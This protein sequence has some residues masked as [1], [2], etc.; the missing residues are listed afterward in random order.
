MFKKF[1]SSVLFV[2]FLVSFNLS[3]AQQGASEKVSSQSPPVFSIPPGEGHRMMGE[4]KAKALSLARQAYATK[5]AVGQGD[6]DA[7]YYGLDLK[8]DTTAK[9]V[10]GA[11]TM[12]GK[13]K[14]A[15]L[16]TVILD[17]MY[18][19]VVDS[20]KEGTNGLAFTHPSNLINITLDRAYALDENFLF[21]VYYHGH[22]L[23]GGFLDFA[24]RY[25]GSPQVPIISS[26]SEPYYA[27]TWWPC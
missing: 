21:T 17:L 20:V 2:L 11:V 9:V 26:L 8:I 16:N 4:A 14:V 22:P 23:E 1:F 6:F 7:L 3:F 25:H 13:S 12:L 15:S 5:I 10:W 24:F 27:R 18:N 19:M